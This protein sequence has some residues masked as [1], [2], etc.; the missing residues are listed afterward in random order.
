MHQRWY[1]QCERYT[2]HAAV[3]VSGEVVCWSRLFSPLMPMFHQFHPSNPVCF[4]TIPT[5]LRQWRQYLYLYQRLFLIWDCRKL[6]MVSAIKSVLLTTS[7]YVE[8]VLSMFITRLFP[9][10]SFYRCCA[11]FLFEFILGSPIGILGQVKGCKI[12]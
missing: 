8:A 12:G 7:T 4:C 5:S 1:C 6:A 10:S 11:T 9:A 3:C 2:S